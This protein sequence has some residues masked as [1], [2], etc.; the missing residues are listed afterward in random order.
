MGPFKHSDTWQRSCSRKRKKSNTATNA[1]QRAYSDSA[2]FGRVL[3]V[4]KKRKLIFFKTKALVRSRVAGTRIPAPDFQSTIYTHFRVLRKRAAN[5]LQRA[6][7]YAFVARRS[8]YSFFFFLVRQASRDFFKWTVCRHCHA[9]LECDL[10]EW[11]PK[12][13]HVFWRKL[14]IVKCE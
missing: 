12:A 11:L 8:T 10:E 3:G 9:I 13:C 5:L 4:L 2:R 1:N 14:R 7:L 6:A